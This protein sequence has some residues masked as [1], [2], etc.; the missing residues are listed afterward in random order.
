MKTSAFGLAFNATAIDTLMP[1]PRVF[2]LFELQKGKYDER[3][4]QAHNAAP[5]LVTDDP[6]WGLF[7]VAPGQEQMMGAAAGGGGE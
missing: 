6:C 2:P 4:R 3:Q 5:R 1:T 7:R